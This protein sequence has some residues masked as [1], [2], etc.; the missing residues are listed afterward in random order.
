VETFQRQRDE[1]A[2][3]ADALNARPG[4]LSARLAALQEDN[5]RLTRE[6]QQA[7]MKAAMGGGSAGAADEAIEVA[8]VK[9]IARE[10]SGL[11]KDGLRS[12]VAASIAHQERS[13]HPR[14]TL[15]RQS[16]DR[17]RRTAD[18]R[19][20]SRGTGVKRIATVGGGGGGRADFAEAGGR[21]VEFGNAATRAGDR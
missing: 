14:I 3:L 8:G 13:R 11:D 18:P 6:L 17:R 19:N 4:E 1:L 10:V 9:L 2:Q 5:K 7:R 20:E 16:H 12:L 21:I 15:R